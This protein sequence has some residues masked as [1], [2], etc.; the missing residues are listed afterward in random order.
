MMIFKIRKALEA[1]VKRKFK[2]DVTD[3]GTMLDGTEADFAFEIND[4]RL[5]INKDQT[6]IA[7]LQKEIE[8]LKLEISEIKESNKN[9]LQ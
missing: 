8:V 7:I 6:A 4:N 3:A 2:A 5:N 1:S 9:P